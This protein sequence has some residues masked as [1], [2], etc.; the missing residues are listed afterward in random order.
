[1]SNNQAFQGHSPS[2]QT[3]T[4][5]HNK[6]AGY[7]GFFFGVSMI[8]R[9]I[10]ALALL[11]SA[12]VAHAAGTVPGFNLTPQF[13]KS[14]KVMPGCKIYVYQAG[15]VATPQNA[16]QDSALTVLQA[17]P[18]VCDASGR[19]PQ[20]FV[21]DGLIKLR[22]TDKN[23]LEAFVGDNLTVI[24]ASSGGGGGGGTIDPTT[25][26]ATGDVKVA[27]GVQVLSGWVRV[28]GRTI[29]SAT[30]GA[31]ERANADTQAL[32]QYLWT[33]DGN[34]AVSGG[35]GVSSIADWTANKTITLPDAQGRTIAGLDVMG[36][37]DNCRLCNG[38]L[39]A[40]R[41]VLGSAGGESG[42]TLTIAEMPAHSHGVNDPGHIHNTTT[43]LIS[44]GGTPSLVSGGTGSPFGNFNFNVGSNTTGI[45]IQNNGGGT[46]HNVMQ[47][48][49]LMTIYL[50]L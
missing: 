42:H 32:F 39:A 8:K 5:Q 15:T 36:G 20:W 41:N 2:M 10:L 30:S 24:G 31:T 50:K 18:M 40:N 48:T 21:A 46:V 33:T 25:I 16:Y 27:Y 6:A 14:G 11:A 7:G 49:I 29:G 26:S 3:A 4:N 43:A 38:N 47:P 19:P 45:T 23:G 28:N 34:L 12:T 1:M 9:A 17:N 44:S 13:D 37:T 35:R 22:V